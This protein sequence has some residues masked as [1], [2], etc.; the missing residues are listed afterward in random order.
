LLHGAECPGREGKKKMSAQDQLMKKA[1]C[2]C[3]LSSSARH[4]SFSS[5]C[6]EKKKSK[7]GEK[8]GYRK[9]KKKKRGAVCQRG[10]V[11]FDFIFVAAPAERKKRGNQKPRKKGRRDLRVYS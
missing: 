6:A 1:A 4:L 11:F 7:E 10:R 8:E 5:D 9:K 3:D 2:A